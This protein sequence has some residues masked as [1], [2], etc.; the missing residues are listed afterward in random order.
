MPTHKSY[1]TAR[2][3]NRFMSRGLYVRAPHR[4]KRIVGAVLFVLIATI[5]FLIGLAEIP[6]LRWLSC[7]LI[8]CSAALMLGF[9]FTKRQQRP[10]WYQIATLPIAFATY[11]LLPVFNL[12]MV[13]AALLILPTTFSV[14]ILKFV[15]QGKAPTPSFIFLWMTFFTIMVTYMSE[16]LVV[17]EFS[18][19]PQWA[20]WSIHPNRIRLF[21]FTLY[22][23]V[24]I[25]YFAANLGGRR[26][27]L[28]E[29]MDAAILQSFAAYVAFDRIISN[30]KA[31]ESP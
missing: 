29:G 19:V 16:R 3:W 13:G 2:K 11:A 8:Y 6:T 17:Q 9:L 15:F 28:Q 12:Y 10:L 7:Y 1:T 14:I 18:K 5:C 24:I 30:W 23:L 26:L 31:L 20:R 21:I 22:F 25:A 27:L 4:E